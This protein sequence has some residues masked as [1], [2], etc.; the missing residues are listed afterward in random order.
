MR[1]LI[2]A[3]IV[4]FIFSCTPKVTKEPPPAG[5]QPHVKYLW[6]YKNIVNVRESNSANSDKLTSLMDGDSV[7]V[8]NNEEGWYEVILNNG[9]KGWIRSDLLGT[10]NLSVFHKAVAFSDSL[11]TNYNIKLYFDKN[12]QHKRIYL[13]YPVDDY[14]SEKM[15]REKTNKLIHKYQQKIY[16]GEISVL[17][18]KPDS[19]DN[20]L[21]LNY[22]GKPNP[23]ISLPVIPFGILEDVTTDAYRE[24]TINII[25]DT[26]LYTEK[27]LN[28]SRKMSKQFPLSFTR[29]QINFV[30]DNSECLFSFVEDSAGEI[31]KFNQCL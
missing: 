21:S 20:Y 28:A 14:T 11:T 15:I 30:S 9:I 4:F 29:V 1:Y 7:Q 2:L 6:V 18:L 25:T 12:L 13:E 16:H 27:F 17:V 23:E 19:Q 31:Y 24:I 10:K 8:L 3:S 26:E 22:K 5:D